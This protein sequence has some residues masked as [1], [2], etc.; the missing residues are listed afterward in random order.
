MSIT[1]RLIKGSPLTDQELDDNFRYAYEWNNTDLYKARMFVLYVPN[2]SL[3]RA[4][5][6]VPAGTIPGSESLPTTYWDL[7]GPANFSFDGTRVITRVGIP[8]IAPG[9]GT[10]YDFLNNFFYPSKA[11]ELTFSITEAIREF[12]H[13]NAIAMPYTVTKHTKGVTAITLNGDTVTVDSDISHDGDP[14]G[15]TQT[16]THSSNATLNVNSTITGSVTTAT[17]TTTF[18]ASLTWLGKKFIFNSA[19]D[20]FTPS[21]NDAA[22][23]SVLNGLGSGFSLSADRLLNQVVTCA[24]EFI[25]MFYLDSMGGDINSNFQINGITYNSFDVKTFTYTNQYGYTA[26][27][28]LIKTKYKLTGEY[29]TQVN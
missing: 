4:K 2:L 15:N 3:Y 22:I 12:G 13:S 23:S 27:F 10:A 8:N 29:L 14:D 6:D 5:V 20:Y 16:G 26:T 18:S 28:R 1:F 24:N 19:I 11:P 21:G 7:V 9:G 25:Y 17:E